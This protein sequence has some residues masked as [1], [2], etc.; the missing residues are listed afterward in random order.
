MPFLDVLILIICVLA[1]IIYAIALLCIVIYCFIEF[2][3]ALA[4]LKKETPKPQPPNEWPLVTLQLPI[5][6]EQF[7]VERLLKHAA[8]LDYPSGKLQIQ[9]LDDSTDETSDFIHSIIRNFPHV[10]FEYIHRT[11]RSGYKAGALANGLQT[12]TGEYIAILDAD[13]AVQPSWLKE[14]LPYIL[15]DAKAAFVQTRWAHLNEHQNALTW[16][17]ALQLDTHFTV[18]QFGRNRSGFLSQFNGTAGIWR[19]QAIEDAGGWKSRTLIEDMDLS[20]RAQLAG[21]HTLIVPSITVAAELPSGISGLKSQQYRW[22]KGG[23]Q[24]ARLFLKDIWTAGHLS[25]FQK[26]HASVHCL[27]SSV[28]SIIL[29]LCLSSLVLKWAIPEFS[30]DLSYLI[31]GFSGTAVLIL[32]YFVST[33]HVKKKKNLFLHLLILP[34]RLLVFFPLAAGIAIHNSAAVWSGWFDTTEAEFVRTPKRGDSLNKVGYNIASSQ[35]IGFL[36]LFLAACFAAS[37]AH[38]FWSGSYLFVEF[39]IAMLIGFGTIGLMTVFERR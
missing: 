21:Y 3:L 14:A 36:E 11:D 34:F 22:N 35:I 17:Q 24:S 31:F 32:V 7:V 19:R 9:I 39:H 30:I 8:A 37:V 33:I 4:S 13:F 28:F 1:F 29:A 5:Y 38:S 26:L 2:W 27:A 10:N 18:E 20:Y 6:N 16:M 12:A 25:F 15:S 23:A